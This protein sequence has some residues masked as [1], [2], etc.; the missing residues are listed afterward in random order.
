[1]TQFDTTLLRAAEQSAALHTS[2][3]IYLQC[4]LAGCSHLTSVVTVSAGSQN[5]WLFQSP[6]QG[7]HPPRTPKEGV[8]PGPKS[9]ELFHSSLFGPS[10]LEPHLRSAEHSEGVKRV[11]RP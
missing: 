7:P 10:V 8:P 11:S 3:R 1:M 5:V 6:P 2:C 9:A 4:V